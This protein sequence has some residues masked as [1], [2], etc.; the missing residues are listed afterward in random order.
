MHNCNNINPVRRRD[1]AGYLA[2]IREI[3]L[4]KNINH[5]YNIYN[6]RYVY[7]ALFF[8]KTITFHLTDLPFL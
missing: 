1:L 2:V 8:I 7:I 5:E 3:Y 4:Y 6:N